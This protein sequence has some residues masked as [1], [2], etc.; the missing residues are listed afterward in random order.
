MILLYSAVLS[1]YVYSDVAL[2][3]RHCLRCHGECFADIPFCHFTP[4]P[5]PLSASVCLNPVLVDR[6]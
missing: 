1:A 3:I 4:L 6:R 5:L 2:H